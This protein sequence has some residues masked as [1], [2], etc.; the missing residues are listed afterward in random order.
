MRCTSDSL[1]LVQLIGGKF[2][3]SLAANGREL[4]SGC[5]GKRRCREEG[6]IEYRCNLR[7]GMIGR[8][9]PHPGSG[10]KKIRN[11]FGSEGSGLSGN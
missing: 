8:K 6:K 4:A 10:L 1:I 5:T 3:R 11:S 9:R 2:A 7:E